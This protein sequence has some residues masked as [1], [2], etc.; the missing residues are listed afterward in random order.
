MPWESRS[1]PGD[2]LGLWEPV[3]SEDSFHGIAQSEDDQAVDKCRKGQAVCVVF[4]QED[5]RNRKCVPEKLLHNHRQAGISAHGPEG[6]EHPEADQ[7]G[8]LYG[9]TGDPPARET[10][11]DGI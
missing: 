5:S 10:E 9:G 1:P 11:R 6:V 3:R 7:G 8:G 2:H 4:C